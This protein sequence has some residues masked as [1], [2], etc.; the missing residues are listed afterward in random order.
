VIVAFATIENWEESMVFVESP[1]LKV[2]VM[3]PGVNWALVAVTGLVVRV[4]ECV[5]VV[6]R[7]PLMVRERV[8][9]DPTGTPIVPEEAQPGIGAPVQAEALSENPVRGA[10]PHCP[11]SVNWIKVGG[12]PVAS[13]A[14]ENDPPWAQVRFRVELLEPEAAGFA[15]TVTVQLEEAARFEVPQLSDTMEKSVG[16]VRDAAAHPVAGPEPELEKVMTCDAEVFPTAMEPKLME[17]GETESTGLVPVTVMAFGLVA[18]MPPSEQLRLRFT[19]AGPSACGFARSETVQLEL[20]ARFAVP[21]VSETIVKSAVLSI[22]GAEQ[23]VALA[24]PELVRVKAW[25]VESLP[26]L[27]PLKS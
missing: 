10:F 8:I 23:P 18:G 17:S 16:L 24:V 26:T 19:T 5:P 25:L 3:V 7:T 1:G 20:G 9:G 27:T 12:I 15:T 11:A 6:E 4:T 21:Q 2:T 22:A 14:E 13:S